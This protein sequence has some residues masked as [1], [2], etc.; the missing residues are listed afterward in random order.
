MHDDTTHNLAANFLNE[1]IWAV[2]SYLKIWVWI[3]EMDNAGVAQ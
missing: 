2:V 1:C 3:W